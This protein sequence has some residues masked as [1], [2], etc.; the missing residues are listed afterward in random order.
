MGVDKA[1][2]QAWGQHDRLWMAGWLA[3]RQVGEEAGM[4]T[5]RQVRVPRRLAGK[6]VGLEAGIKAG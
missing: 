2:R 1:S 5:G 6:T 3:K 4:H